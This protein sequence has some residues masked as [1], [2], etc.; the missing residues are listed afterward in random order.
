MRLFGSGFDSTVEDLDYDA[1]SEESESD[2]EV[3]AS[4]SMRSLIALA[5][6]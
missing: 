6:S 2:E 1:D 3:F 5:V 4:F